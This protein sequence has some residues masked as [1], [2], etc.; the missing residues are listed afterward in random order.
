MFEKD[1]EIQCF[2]SICCSADMKIIRIVLIAGTVLILVGVLSMF[3]Y[4][5]SEYKEAVDQLRVEKNRWMRT[6]AESPFSRDEKNSFKSLTYFPVDDTYKVK[7]AVTFLPPGD[8]LFYPVLNNYVDT[9]VKAAT[10]IFSIDTKICSL[11]A[12]SRPAEKQGIWFIPFKD[13]TNAK[14]TYGGGRYLDIKVP[15][16]TESEIDFNLAYN[17][18]CAYNENYVCVMPPAYNSLPVSIPVG[19]KQFLFS[20]E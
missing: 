19:E 7:A 3:F 9:L 5:E 17:P 6:N 11:T 20:K 10:F 18:Y 15:E 1:S 13:A 12:F 2:T 8:T 16:T 14:E 4:S